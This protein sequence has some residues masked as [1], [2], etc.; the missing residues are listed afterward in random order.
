MRIM[1]TGGAGYIGS[2]ITEELVKANHEV[3]VFDNLS[4]GH[5]AAVVAGAR[6]ME[7]ELENTALLKEI[8][9]QHQI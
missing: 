8:F 5:R 6:L 2:I 4:K 7:G 1:V 3:V 9:T